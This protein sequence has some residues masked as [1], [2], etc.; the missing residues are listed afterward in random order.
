MKFRLALVGVMLAVISVAAPRAASAQM[1]LLAGINVA[2]VT[3]DPEP[4]FEN[5]SRVGFVGGVAFNIPMGVFSFEVDALFSQKGTELTFTEGGRTETLKIRTNN[6]EFPLLG[7]INVPGSGPAR[8]H[9]LVGPSI[10][11]KINENFDPE[12]DEDDQL[13]RV[14]GTLVVGAGFTIGSVGLEGRYGIGLSNI[15]NDEDEDDFTGKNRVFSI[16]VRIGS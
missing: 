13:E 11:F 9:L 6:L 5:A 10:N 1:G 3:F 2:N 14:E 7:R 4:D 8:F 12:E 16:L 15:I